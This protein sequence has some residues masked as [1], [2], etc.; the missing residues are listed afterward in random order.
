MKRTM[1]GFS[2]ATHR[3][4]MMPDAVQAL[5]SSVD[6]LAALVRPLDDTSL[7]RRSFCSQWTIADVLSHLGSGATITRRYFQTSFENSEPPDDFNP[8]RVWD[9]WNAKSPR[10]KA[11]DALVADSE[12]MNVLEM[13]SPDDRARFKVSM[14][15][16]EFDWDAFVGMRLNEHLVHEWDVAVTLDPSATLGAEGTQVVVDNLER[17]AKFA[18][19]AQ[20][21]SRTITIST[22][23]PERSFSVVTGPE[24]VTFCSVQ[25]GGKAD[26]SM[27]AESLIRLVYGRLD[28]EHTRASVQGDH[29]LLDQLRLVFPGV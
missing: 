12:L 21:D 29:S 14:G 23:D 9:E 1:I 28:P 17:V 6:R 27:S 22:T 11:D 26:L 10:Q 20:D 2:D 24:Q 16:R 7:T 13:T 19:K 18:S 4:R 3:V 5:R 15:P 8:Q 25:L